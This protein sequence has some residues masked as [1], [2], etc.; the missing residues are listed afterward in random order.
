MKVIV[1]L[2]NPEGRYAKTRHN[3]GFMVVDR[4]LG[5]FVPSEPLKARFN[6]A[7]AEANV[8]GERCLFM[9]P[10]TY[11]NRSGQAVGEAVR[12][13]K[14]DP[15]REL[16]VV[17][18]DLYLPVGAIRFKPG[19]GAAGH[20]GLA[21]IER[22][23]GADGYPRLR[24]DVGMRPDGGK[25]PFMDQADFVLSQFMAEEEAELNASLVKAA[26][27]AEVFIGK[28]LDAAMNAF[29]KPDTPPRMKPPRP[30]PQAGEASQTNQN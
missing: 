19:G 14:I 12:F 30:P 16:L 1:G 21:D 4:L 9:K 18:D 15:T 11:M 8:G 28:G 29:N 13:Y 17:V 25:P 24:V 7:T 23:L 3:A 27:A 26:E 5:K 6:S 20:N 10:I 2:G 22:N